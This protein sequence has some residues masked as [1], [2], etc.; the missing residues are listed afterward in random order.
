MQENCDQQKIQR[1]AS[2]G[3]TGMPWEKPEL[4]NPCSD[5]YIPYYA[6]YVADSLGDR[7]KS[8]LYYTIASANNDTPEASRFLAV[9]EE[10]K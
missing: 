4:R 1:I 2:G 7:E 9:L 5:G 8:S 6:A 10:G 3:I